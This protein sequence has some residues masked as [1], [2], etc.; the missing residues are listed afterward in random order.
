MVR[1]VHMEGIEK[2][3]ASNSHLETQNIV[4]IIAEFE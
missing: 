2:Q 4:D 3:N 1:W